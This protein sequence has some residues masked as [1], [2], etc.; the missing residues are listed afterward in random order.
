[1]S[2]EELPAAERIRCR[3]DFERVYDTGTRIRGR[4]MTVFVVPREGAG[5]RLGVAATRRL[6]SAVV[7]NRAKRLARELFRRHKITAALDIVIAPRREMLDA[8]YSSLES[9]YLAALERGRAQGPH[10]IGSKAG[11]ARCPTA[12]TSV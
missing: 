4:Y 3:P 12:V 1:M 11:R 10:G 2:R 6:G 5:P 8:S 9:D 7:R